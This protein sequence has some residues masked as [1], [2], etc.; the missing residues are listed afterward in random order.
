MKESEL[1]ILGK[2]S[3]V[4]YAIDKQTLTDMRFEVID[5]EGRQYVRYDVD[6]EFSMQDDNKTLK[7]FVNKR[8]EK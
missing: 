2:E 5:E 4:K 1:K 6:V 7:I 8:K 3:S